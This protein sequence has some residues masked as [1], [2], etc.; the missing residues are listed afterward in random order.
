MSDITNP[1]T[2][3]FWID[4]H[5]R[6]ADLDPLGHANNTAIGTYFESAR[7]SLFE[8]AGDGVTGPDAGVVLARI[9]IDYR[10]ELRYPARLRIGVR[11]GRIGTTSVTLE[12]AVFDGARCAASSEAVCVLIDTSARRPTALPEALRARLTD[13]AG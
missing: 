13:A 9:V 1:E 6:F 8:Q 4:E 2:Y 3:R 11:V 5:V 10:A 12:S 7:V